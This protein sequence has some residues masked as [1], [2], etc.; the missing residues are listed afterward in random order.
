MREP[1]EATRLP[2]SDQRARPNQNL[3]KVRV[4]QYPSTGCPLKGSQ[5]RLAAEA[6]LPVDHGC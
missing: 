3:E 6:D 2:A 4:N 5:E 1:S